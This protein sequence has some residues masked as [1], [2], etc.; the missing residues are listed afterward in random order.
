MFSRHFLVQAKKHRIQ[1]KNLDDDE[2]DDED[3]D[4]D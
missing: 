1:S 2:H 3:D 4:D